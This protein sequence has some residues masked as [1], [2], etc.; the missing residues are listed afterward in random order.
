VFTG[1]NGQ[2]KTSLLEAIAWFALGRSFRS[3][4]DEV[5]V[6][7]GA[8]EAVLSIEVSD[9][10]ERVHRLAA[11]I[12]RSGRTRVRIDGKNTVRKR[13][14]GQFLQVTVFGPDDLELVKGSPQF[15]RDL[16]DDLLASLAPRYEAA[17]ADTERVVKQRNAA[18]RGFADAEATLDVLDEQFARAGAELVKGR[19]RLLERLIDPVNEAY[20]KLSGGGDVELQYDAAWLAPEEEDIETALMQE[21]ARNRRRDQERGLTTSGPQR[22]DVRVLLD[23]REARSQASQG[24]VRSLALSLRLASHAVVEQLIGDHPVVLLDDVFSEL[25]NRRAAALADALPPAQTLVTSA[26]GVPT[27]LRADHVVAV[28]RDIFQ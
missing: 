2:G 16:L 10:N 20:R 27:G 4:T 11:Q 18:L 21:L 12:P 15:R 14:G 8:D 28:D 26:I 25:D 23:S 3:S 13:D 17:R 9:S 19:R 24:E 1:D 22:D 5:M 7:T 6:R